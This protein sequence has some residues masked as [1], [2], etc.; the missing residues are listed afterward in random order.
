[1]S[2]KRKE[3]G[4]IYL[5]NPE[6]AKEEYLKQNKRKSNLFEQKIQDYTFQFIQIKI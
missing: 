3:I 2:I 4:I 1:M 5:K 6:K